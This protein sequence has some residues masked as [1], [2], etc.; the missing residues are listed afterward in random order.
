[1]ELLL[2][3]AKCSRWRPDER[4]SIRSLL[5]LHL[6]IHRLRPDCHVFGRN[7]KHVSATAL[8]RDVNLLTL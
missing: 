3:V 8:W 2:T 4:W 7:G 6:D 5:E 1:M